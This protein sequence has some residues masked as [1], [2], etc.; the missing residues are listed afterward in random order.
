MKTM[1]VAVVETL[2][3]QFEKA[4]VRLSESRMSA[5][6]AIVAGNRNK[7]IISIN[8][9]LDERSKFHLVLHSY[10]H[11]ARGHIADGS[12]RVEYV[13]PFGSHDPQIEREELEA[14][15]QVRLW[16]RNA[17]LA[18]LAPSLSDQVRF[19]RPNAE[20]RVLSWAR[21]AAHAVPPLYSLRGSSRRVAGF[22]DM[23]GSELEKSAES[24]CLEYLRRIEAK[25]AR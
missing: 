25:H 21:R 13:N 8:R 11:F 9:R 17:D 7:A 12:I 23:L 2:A 14:E 15:E 1:P 4:G 24:S 3:P 6:S 16:L 22:C 10:A 20:L 19:I 5:L 18:L